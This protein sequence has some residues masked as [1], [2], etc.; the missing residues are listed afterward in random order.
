[1]DH[2]DYQFRDLKNAMSVCFNRLSLNIYGYNLPS[3]NGLSLES[4]SLAQKF[5]IFAS[6]NMSYPPKISSAPSPVNTTL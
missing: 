3:S 6:L 2:Q 4:G 5:L 1:M